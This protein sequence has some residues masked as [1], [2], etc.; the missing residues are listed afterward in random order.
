[1][2]HVWTLSF[3]AARDDTCRCD[4]MVSNDGNDPVE[5]SYGSRCAWLCAVGHVGCRLEVDPQVVAP[6]Q[7]PG[8]VVT[9]AESGVAGPSDV[10][11]DVIWCASRARRRGPR[12]RRRAVRRRAAVHRGRPRRVPREAIPTEPVDYSSPRRADRKITAAAPSPTTM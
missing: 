5:V 8:D 6:P 2:C 1:M 12:D 7:L 3:M 9:V 10:V 11:D 4:G